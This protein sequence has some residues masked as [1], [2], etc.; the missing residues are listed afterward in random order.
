MSTAITSPTSSNGSSV[1]VDSRDG[2][3]AAKTATEIEAAP[4]I[5]VFA[6]P[7]S[8]AAAASRSQA[9]TARSGT[10]GHLPPRQA[11]EAGGAKVLTRWAMAS[12]TSSSD[13]APSTVISHS[14]RL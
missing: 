13:C 1:P 8:R 3:T 6:K 9:V 11:V 12:W 14:R 10:A 2:S 4:P 5:E 7:T